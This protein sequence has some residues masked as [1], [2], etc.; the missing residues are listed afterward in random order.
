MVGA[1][2]TLGLAFVAG[3]AAL[4]AFDLVHPGVF[5]AIPASVLLVG[6]VFLIFFPGSLL[7]S[8]VGPFAIVVAA[9][10]AA[11]VEIRYY[12]WMSPG[13]PPM[14]SIPTTLVGREGIV[15][16]E[17]VPNTLKGKVRVDSEIWSARAPVPIPAGTTV[18]VVGGEG[19]AVLVEPAS[20]THQA[21]VEG[22]R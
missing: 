3:G 21:T 10:T 22:T 18:K 20:R 2:D 15:V 17:V 12:R 16:A 7:G 13:H 19:V 8:A 11:L 1:Y 14:T 5:S 9:I 4:L 6:G